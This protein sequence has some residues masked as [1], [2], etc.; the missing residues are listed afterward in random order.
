ML[1]SAAAFKTKPV[2]KG[3]L[4]ILLRGWRRS[5]DS[6]QVSVRDQLTAEVALYVDKTGGWPLSIIFLVDD[7]PDPP[8]IDCSYS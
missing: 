5:T 2:S 1:F 6:R 4:E 7:L 3:R 8:Q